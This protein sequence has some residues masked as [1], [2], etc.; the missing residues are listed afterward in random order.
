MTLRI[1][2]AIL[3]LAGGLFAQNPVGPQ[4]LDTTTI[5]MHMLEPPVPPG[6]VTIG[7]TGAPG[8]SAKT[9]YYWLVSNFTVGNSTVGGPYPGFNAPTT[10]SVSNF[11]TVYWQPALGANS[12]DLL[13]TSTPTPP[14]GA[15][16]CAVATGITG[17]SQVDQ[18]NSL[19]AYTVTTFPPNSALLQLDAEA[20]G[21]GAANVHMLLKQNNVLVCDLSIGCGG[22]GG[23]SPPASPV[24]SIQTNADGVHFA[25]ITNVAPGSAL[26]SQGPSTVP[27]FQQKAIYDVRD[28]MTCNTPRGTQT[29]TNVTAQMSALINTIGTS[30]RATIRLIGAS[31]PS[32]TCLVANLYYPPNISLNFSGGGAL[33]LL[34][35]STAPSG[36]AIDAA[37]ST[38]SFNANSSSCSVTVTPS[39]GGESYWLSTGFG[40]GG[41]AL[42][43]GQ[44]SSTIASDIILFSP[45][46]QSNINVSY[47]TDGWLVANVASGTRTFTFNYN[48]S[49]WNSCR[50]VAVSGTGVTPNLDGAGGSTQGFNSP[51]SSAAAT[52]Q[53]GSFL[54]GYGGQ[55]NNT[56]TCTAGGPFTQPAAPLGQ[57]GTG[58]TD[59][60]Q[61]LASSSAGALTATQAISSAPTG[62]QWTYNVIG[63]RPGSATVAI[64]GGVEDPDLHPI[65]YNAN[66]GQGYV[67][68]TGNLTDVAIHPEWWGASTLNAAANNNGPVQAAIFGAFGKNRTNPS[69]L[70]VYNKELVFTGPYQIS[71]ETQWYHVIGNKAARNRISCFN[72]GLTQIAPNLR[73]LDGQSIA[74]TN[75]YNCTWTGTNTSTKPLVDLD[76]DG[77]TTPGDLA[78]QQI[79]FYG[80]T[81]NGSGLVDSGVLISKTGGGAQGSNIYCRDGC[82]FE[83]FTGAGWQIGGNNTGRN[84]GRFYAQNALSIGVYDSDFQNCP[85]YGVANYGGG[86]IKIDNSSFECVS[87]WANYLPSV[88]TA[89][90]VYSEASQGP[91]Q[92]NLVR[93]EDLQLAHGSVLDIRQSSNTS[94]A[95]S[96]WNPGGACLPGGSL[97]LNYFFTGSDVGGDGALYQV[98]VHGTAFSG[99]CLQFASSGTGT[100]IV[101][102]T[103]TIPG[104]LTIGSFVAETVTQAVSG[105]SGTLV[106]APASTGTV[107]GSVTSGTIGVGDAVTQ[108]VTGITAKVLSPAPTGSG[109]LLI[110]NLSGTADSSHTW[111]DGTTSGVY[112]P[113]AAPTFSPA[114]P[115]LILGVIT[116]S[117]DGTHNWVGGT[118]GA[119]YVPSGSPANTANYTV[120]AYAGQQITIVGGTGAGEIC[121]PINSNTATAFTCTASWSTNYSGLNVV[122]PDVTSQFIVEPYW[123][124]GATT[125]GDFTFA[126]VNPVI[127]G[128]DTTDPTSSDC[129]L[130]RVTANA[131]YI[132]CGPPLSRLTNVSVTRAD[133]MHGTG[134]FFSNTAINWR[135]DNITISRP[136]SITN[137][138]SGLTWSIGNRNGTPTV[139][140][141]PNQNNPGTVPEIWTVGKFGGNLSMNDVGVGG[142]TYASM[143]GN[144]LVTS[145]FLNML[146]VIGGT[147]GPPAPAFTT[148]ANGNLFRVMGGPPLGAGI[149]GDIAFA[150]GQSG[151]SGVTL[152]DGVDRWLIKGATGHLF[153]K[154]DN[155]YDIGGP[156]D[157]RPRDVNAARTGNFATSVVTPIVALSANITW[158]AGAGVPSA[159]SC[160]AANGGSLFSR[161]DGTPTTTLYVCDNS[162][163][164]WTA[165]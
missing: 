32:D 16:N 55:H 18:S 63:I 88:A 45:N 115:T 154:V 96:W 131:G 164:T 33:T 28:S 141:G 70:N 135:L 142:R 137:P 83:G 90:D 40:F 8:S 80:N 5:A 31:N 29:G 66:P 99:L 71:A 118:S 13:R 6:G 134:G 46:F 125:S 104:A 160:T 43:T 100:T 21:A 85:L 12:Y 139:F 81:F 133:W 161:T 39:S 54:I 9:V 124:G 3:L 74:Y 113:S 157:N 126:K 86:Y 159:G 7:F 114:N 78:P 162:T 52:F 107:T 20:I 53:S 58:G 165:K 79:N 111:V 122:N 93:S 163:H 84:A 130:D 91:M 73:I 123:A 59:C 95:A 50:A 127:V 68:F 103:Q 153:A 47:L 89:V 145:N 19:S 152:A 26:V 129:T 41:G 112:T 143:I 10:L 156:A 4:P 102:L 49:T 119:V 25:A 2:F 105:A 44:P 69:G 121:G 37:G 67:D 30:Q 117:P 147:I 151:S 62:L 128:G 116:G 14:T 97:P 87:P 149:P 1:T 60:M 51:M 72:G 108:S 98:T 11:F 48:G 35:D 109:N 76:F 56:E 146:E 82:L 94:Q 106:Q 22:G 24:T 36:G 61:Y 23:G 64:L 101:N 15:C 38:A 65:F 77:V 155:T 92:L 144:S 34:T 42:L 138:N 148:D 140:N 27:A 136:Y 132:Q 57:V 158:T 110:N 150:T 17:I 120:N 75:F